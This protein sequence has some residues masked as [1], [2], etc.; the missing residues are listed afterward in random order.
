MPRNFSSFKREISNYIG[1]RLNAT[2]QELIGIWINQGIQEIWAASSWD[3]KEKRIRTKTVAPYTTGTITVNNGSAIVTGSGTTFTSAMVGRKFAKSIGTPWSY[4]ESVDSAT[5]ITLEEAWEEDTLTSSTYNIFADEIELDA[6]VKEIVSVRLI[7][8][9]RPAL[10]RIGLDDIERYQN[11][12]ATSGQP[13]YWY[14]APKNS[15]TSNIVIGLWPVPD[16]IYSVEIRYNPVAP[17]LVSDEDTIEMMPVDFE[18]LITAYALEQAANFDFLDQK[19]VLAAQRFEKLLARKVNESTS[20]ADPEFQ[21][22]S[23]DESGYP[24]GPYPFW[25]NENQ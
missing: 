16:D 23:F 15:T 21:F 2:T 18:P 8:G 12:S 5:Q 11:L 1:D 24:Q 19:S 13:L 4:I 22:R 20:A 6:D 3:W 17:E 14:V 25:D 9:Y 7:T 10:R